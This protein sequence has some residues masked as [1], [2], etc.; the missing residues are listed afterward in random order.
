MSREIGWEGG[1]VKVGLV[2]VLPV[3]LLDMMELE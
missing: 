2:M 3:V 1:V